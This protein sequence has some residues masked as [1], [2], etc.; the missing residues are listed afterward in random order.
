ML[1]DEVF[2]AQ[3]G[4][5]SLTHVDFMVG[6]PFIDVDGILANGAREAPI[7]AGEWA[8]LSEL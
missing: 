4:N 2:A 7:R 1:T 5:T 3:G 6:G 8:E